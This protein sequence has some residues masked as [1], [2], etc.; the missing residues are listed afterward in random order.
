[1]TCIPTGE[2]TALVR[3]VSAQALALF[4]SGAVPIANKRPAGFDPVTDADRRLEELLRDGLRRL[5]GELPVIGEEY[6]VTGDPT[7]GLAWI[8]DPI[9]GTRAFISGQP[10]WGTLVGLL[11]DGRP[12]GGWMHL[13]V[14]GESYWAHGQDAGVDSPTTSRFGTSGCR[15]LADATV[16]ATHPDMFEPAL[17][18]AY[19]RIFGSARLTRFGGDC[20]NYGLLATGD[21]DAVVESQLQSYDIVPLQPIIEAAGGVV[22]GAGGEPPTGGGT[23]VAAATAELHAEILALM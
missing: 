16:A 7:A 13:P 3:A 5:V 6:G 12:I 15:S 14:L 8:V 17:T 1:M 19:E 22:T 21:I 20:H 2:V 11:D 9:D 10:Q 4:R 23:V 18:E